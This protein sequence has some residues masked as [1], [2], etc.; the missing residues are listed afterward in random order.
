MCLA[1][2]AILLVVVRACLQSVTIDEADSFLLFAGQNWPAQWYPSSGNHVLNTLL[3]R[4]VTTAFGVNELTLRTPAILGAL[5]Y[6]AAAFYL[7]S[8]LTASAVLKVPFFVALVYNPMILDYLVAARGYSLASGFLLAALAVLSS[9]VLSSEQEAL[10]VRRKCA[11]IS[12]FLALSASANFAFAIA[13]GVTLL[14]CFLWAARK[15]GIA[16]MA[17]SC[18]LPGLVVGFVLCGSVIWE[19][20]KGQ[21]YFGSQSLVEMTKGL[22]SAS[23]DQLNADVVNPLLL[24]GLGKI[25]RV[26]PILGTLV[27]LALGVSAEFGQWRS[28]KSPPAALLTLFRLLA[29][30]AI[31]TLLAHWFAFHALR[32]LLPKDRTGLFFVIFF[33]VIYGSALALRFETRRGALAD[34]IGVAVLVVV[35][36]YFAGC[37]R[38]GSFREWHFNADTKQVYWAAD[39]AS[40]RCGIREF[41]TQWMYPGVLNF[42]KRAYNNHSLE[43]P[44]SDPSKPLPADKAAYVLYQPE[45]AGFIQAQKLKLVFRSEQ[46]DTVIAVRGCEAE[47]GTASGRP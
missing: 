2:G 29:G 19:W 38:L 6:V 47:T 42:Y 28:K 18:F 35:A 1:V 23:F 46:T 10:A 20:P 25:Q 5:I 3:E 12:V 15:Q 8:R 34:W 37:V 24:K 39:Y 27:V 30:I 36:V 11:W 16:R 43:F 40:R 31:A 32:L 7:C 26:L 41:T 9:A 44:S 4:L 14:F 21:L 45:F 13:D 17:V 33:T 22:I